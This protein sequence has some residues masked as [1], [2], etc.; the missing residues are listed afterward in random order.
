MNLEGGRSGPPGVG[1][2]ISGDGYVGCNR[3]YFFFE[4]VRIGMASPEVNGSV[5]ADGFSVPG[6]AD[7]GQHVITSSCSSSGEPVRAS[8][9]FVVTE[10]EFHRAAV[11]TSL[12]NPDQV[13][14]ELERLLASMAASGLVILLFAFPSKLFNGTVEENYDEIRAWFRRPAR[15]VETASTAA[16]TVTFFVLNALAGIALGFLSPDFGLDMNSLVLAVAFTLSLIVMSAGWSLPTAIGIHRRTGEWGK[17]NFLPGTLLVSIVLVI[18]CRL[19]EIQPGYFYGALAG[20]AFAS[21][22]NEESQGRLVAANWTWAL[23]I[24]LASWFF[25]LRVS[26]IAAEPEASLLWIGVEAFLVMTFLWGIET[27][28]VAMLP[29]RFMDGPKVKAW[30]RG[31]WAALLFAGVFATVHVL[32]VPTS[33]YVG[34]TET[35]VAVDV[36]TVFL[37][38]CA[39][40]VATW[41]YFRYRP[42]RWIPSASATTLPATPP[43]SVGGRA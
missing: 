31:V 36:L 22:L 41:A 8:S 9:T 32:L 40:S 2:V 10:A 11:V 20:F 26:E 24:S 4:G 42:A 27:L 21:A 17:L 37:V 15:A 6:D 38:F 19:L 18:I 28:A 30:N 3:V 33:G 1:L 7:P 35:E 25:R 13:S 14:L 39:F 29:M 23:V 12:A 16:R 43:G 5:T 34:Q